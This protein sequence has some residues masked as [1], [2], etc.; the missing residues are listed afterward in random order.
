[1]MLD[2]SFIVP[3]EALTPNTSL[4]KSVA[5]GPT[6]KA[7]K[8]S[9]YTLSVTILIKPCTLLLRAPLHFL[10]KKIV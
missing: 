7:P 6:I 9:P 8:T 4:I 1:M 3:S 2:N 10:E 5:C